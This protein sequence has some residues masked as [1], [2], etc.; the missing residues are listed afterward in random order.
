MEGGEEQ[1]QRPHDPWSL[2]QQRTLRNASFTLVSDP[3]QESLSAVLYVSAYDLLQHKSSL[4]KREG[5]RLYVYRSV[6]GSAWRTGRPEEQDSQLLSHGRDSEIGGPV[7][8]Q[9]HKRDRTRGL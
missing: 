2:P 7:R 4:L 8:T 1:I 6:F 5:K 3:V 9:Q